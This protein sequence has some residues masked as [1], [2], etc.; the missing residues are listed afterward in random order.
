MIPHPAIREMRI[1]TIDRL[2]RM[3]RRDLLIQLHA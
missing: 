1:C 2:I 3:L